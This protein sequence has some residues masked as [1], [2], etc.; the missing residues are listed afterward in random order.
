[1]AC[2]VVPL[3]GRRAHL[4]LL[5]Q[6]VSSR[7]GRG[8]PHCRLLGVHLVVVVVVVVVAEVVV[9]VVVVVV[10]KGG[11]GGAGGAEVIRRW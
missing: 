8:S 6:V 1:M 2:V 4:V 9:V 3:H 10:V 11:G 7:R 5:L